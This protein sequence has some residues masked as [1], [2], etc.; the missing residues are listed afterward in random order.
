MDHGRGLRGSF[1]MLNT[2]DSPNDAAVC[3]LSSV[4]ETGLIQPRYYLSAKAC[5]GI[6]RRAEKRGKQLPAL[7]Y[8]ALQAVASKDVE[9]P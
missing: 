9:S 7:L 8:Q 1:G 3:S 4:L 2:T 6:L 5:R